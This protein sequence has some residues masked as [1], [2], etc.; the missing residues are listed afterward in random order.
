ME[1]GAPA[2][3]GAGSD[4]LRFDLTPLRE[5][6]AKG[7]PGAEETISGPRFAAVESTIQG[8]ALSVDPVEKESLKMT[9]VEAI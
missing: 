6:Q 8:N 3:E 1:I 5:I 7:D 9:S 4:E 2:K